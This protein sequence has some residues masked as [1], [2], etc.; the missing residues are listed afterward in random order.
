MFALC[1]LGFSMMATYGLARPAVDALF[2]EQHGSSRLPSVWLAVSA[3]SLTVVAIY[4]RF[5]AS[6]RILGLYGAACAIV[7]VLF[8]VALAIRPLHPA[9]VTFVM[10]VLKDVYIIVLI[11]IFWTY[12]NTVFDMKSARALYGLFLA[13]GSAGSVAGGTLVGHLVSHTSIDTQAS[14]W[15]LPP[16]LGFCSTLAFS[17][18]RRFGSPVHEERTREWLQVFGVI[19]SNRFVALL[20][21]LVVTTQVVITLIDYDFN[22]AIEASFGATDER[23]H[24]LQ[25]VNVTIELGSIILQ[26]MTVVILRAIGIAGS[27]LALPVLLTGALGVFAAVPA[28]ATMAVAKVVSKVLDYSIFRTGKELLYIPLGYR[29]KTEGKALV[30]MFGYRGGKAVA[31]ALLAGLAALELTK[32][33]LG[34]TLGLIAVWATLTVLILRQHR[35]MA[36]PEEVARSA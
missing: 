33:V 35:N 9:S 6:R 25:L 12:A 3:T 24:A 4:N 8:A 26:L 17:F 20:F 10:Y 15:V 11:E 2:L 13:V 1:L 31:S 16:L 7:A 29:D 14:L 32:G 30:D 5:A 23:T 18:A 28:Y 27:L 19:R 22:R 36:I 21:A 34:L